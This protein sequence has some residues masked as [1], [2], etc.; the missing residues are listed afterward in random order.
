MLMQCEQYS[1]KDYSASHCQPAS[2]VLR[3]VPRPAALHRQRTTAP[4]LISPAWGGLYNGIDEWP[5]AFSNTQ[6]KHPPFGPPKPRA[7]VTYN[8]S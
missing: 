7:L 6:L 5:P 1:T 2:P 8:T 4:S 3:P